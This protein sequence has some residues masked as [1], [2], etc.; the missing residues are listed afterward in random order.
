M[1]VCV[2][3]LK[4]RLGRHKKLI[5]CYHGIH[6]NARETFYAHMKYISSRVVPAFNWNDSQDVTSLQP[7]VAVT[8]DD[9]YDNLLQNAIPAMRE[10]GIQAMIF[11]VSGNFG[12]IPAWEMHEE[13]L[14]SK[15]PLM[16]EKEI[17]NLDGDQFRI[18]SHTVSHPD[19]SVLNDEELFHELSESKK[20]LEKLLQR[21]VTEIALPF[22]A[23]NDNVINQA[24]KIGYKRIYTLEPKTIDYN[25]DP[26]MAGRFI[27]TTD[28]WMIE[29]YLTCAGAYSWLYSFR[30][31]INNLRRRGEK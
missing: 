25:S 26:E 14:K 27:M 1:A 21:P 28:V 13:R 22:G 9:A 8:F 10:L 12:K 31:V 4:G 20:K 3:T 6:D 2:F 7:A 17:I 29:F 15:E 23:F 5:L 19:L 11:A 18:G 30:A 16:A 24:E